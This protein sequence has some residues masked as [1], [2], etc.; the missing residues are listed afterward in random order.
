MTISNAVK[1]MLV[2]FCTISIFACTKYKEQ[3]INPDTA[4]PNEEYSG[5]LLGTTF[6]T[7][8]DAFG[9]SGTGLSPDERSH[10]QNGNSLFRINWVTAPAS[11]TG[12]DGVGPIFNTRSC[13][14]C[15]AKDGRGRPPLNETEGLA[16][17]LIRL[18]I[19]GEDSFGGPLP[20]PN[21]GAQ[22][23][24]SAILGV[25]P[26][27]DAAIA[28]TEVE[29]T[30]PDGNTYSLRNP[31]YSFIDLNYGSMHGSVM[32]SPRVGN[33]MYGLG[34]LEAVPEATLLSYA[35]ETDRDGDGI[36]GIPN[37]VWNAKSRKKEIGRFGWKAN[38]PNLEQQIAGAFLGD[39]GITTS[40]NPTENL[41]ALQVVL[42][43]SLAAG[44]NPELDDNDLADVVFYTQTLAVPGRRNWR[45]PQ[46]LAGKRLFI[47]AQCGKCHI[48]S[49]L[50]G[51]S[52]IP[53]LSNQTIRPY[54][55]LLL[56]DMG[57]GLADGRPDFKAKG[58]EWRTPPLWG[59]YLVKTVNNH[60]MLLHDGR[61]RNFEEA[62][63]WHGGEALDAKNKFRNYSIAERDAVIKFLESL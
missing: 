30:Y 2:V 52:Q 8:V 56:H 14:G 48:P 9:H 19:P 33:Q 16:S 34:L 36:S 62:I 57:E 31:K 28:Y 37:N 63:L 20:D 53:Q 29:G 46:V 27:G 10:F 50:T 42:Y 60:T 44:G 58:N 5:G 18:S 49:M 38:Q 23:S 45:D 51:T 3:I 35:D 25:N 7:S 26:E 43:G 21:Y 54:T 55:D 39:M 41:T 40:L 12:I 6:D 22:L 24:N 47:N 1:R 13:S 59:L 17:M 4:E 11:T 32:L 15:H 61:A